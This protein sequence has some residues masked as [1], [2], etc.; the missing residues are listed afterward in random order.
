MADISKITIKDEEY[1]L[2][3]A[4]ARASL[5]KIM[6]QLN[7]SNWEKDGIVFTDSN[8]EAVVMNKISY[9]EGLRDSIYNYIAEKIQAETVS[10]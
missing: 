7:L 9:E 1:N 3:D 2:A 4:T 10:F 5:N 6:T 8:G